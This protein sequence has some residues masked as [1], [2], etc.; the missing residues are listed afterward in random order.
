VYWQWRCREDT[1]GQSVEALPLSG[2]GAAGAADLGSSSK[3]SNTKQT[4]NVEVEEGSPATSF[5]RGLV[6]N[7]SL[8]GNPLCVPE[9]PRLGPGNVTVKGPHG[10][11]ADAST[12]AIPNR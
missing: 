4:L 10:L 11:D 5:A 1:P 7:L 12:G 8:T 3:Y 6:G 9:Q 2:G